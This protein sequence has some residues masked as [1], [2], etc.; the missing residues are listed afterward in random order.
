MKFSGHLS[1]AVFDR[2]DISTQK[3]VH[4]AGE[5]LAAYLQKNGDKTGT[6][7]HQ[8]AAVVLPIS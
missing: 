6:D 3:D 7:V 2:Y 5:R 8:D 1:R 4:E